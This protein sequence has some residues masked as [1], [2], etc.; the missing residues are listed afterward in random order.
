[1]SK[2]KAEK[3]K[4]IALDKGFEVVD[5]PGDGDCM[6]H[7]LS[8]QLNLEGISCVSYKELRA[9]IADYVEQVSCSY[10]VNPHVFPTLWLYQKDNSFFYQG[11]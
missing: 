7:A 2:G 10:S 11:L 5:N 3:L 4:Q 1:M 9:T 8:H 6:Y